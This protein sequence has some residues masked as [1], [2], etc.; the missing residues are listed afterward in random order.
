[1]MEIIEEKFGEI[2]FDNTNHLPGVYKM[3][4]LSTVTNGQ[5]DKQN[6]G[7]D[8]EDIKEDGTGFN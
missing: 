4:C 5:L 7:F 6:E 8:S 1:M 3:G 2:T